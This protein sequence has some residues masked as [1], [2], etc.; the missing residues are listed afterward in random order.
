M[1]RTTRRALRG[2]ASLALTGAVALGSL[3]AST[4]ARAVPADYRVID[5][6]PTGVT[7]DALPTTQID[8]VAWDQKIAGNTV[9][10]GGEFANARPAGAAAGTNLV[11]RANL[12]AYDITTGKLV[13]SFR[14]DTNAAVNVLALSPDGSRLYVGGAF[15]TVGGQN[16]YRLAAINTA[17]GSL[18]PNFAPSI[19]ASVNSIVVTDDA[20]YVGGVFSRANGVA[21]TRLAAFSPADG[22]LLAWAPT[23]NR[24]VKA[25]TVSP[26]GSR[27]IVGGQFSTINGAVSPGTGSIDAV[28]GTLYPFALNKV[29]KNG[30]ANTGIYSLTT[31]G[32]T[33]VGTAFNYGEGLYEGVFMTDPMTGAITW[34]ADCHGDS[35]DATAMRGQVYAVSHHHNCSNVGSFPQFTPNIYK[36]ADAWTYDATGTV[37]TNSQSGYTNYA[38]NPAPS[39]VDW[40]PE[41]AAGT[42]T[43]QAQAAWTS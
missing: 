23:A 12:L 32:T 2:T 31:D 37:K 29:V 17:D 8:G 6:Q 1:S 11:P 34:L 43:G 22:S 20:V 15:T 14:A 21:R 36:R 30:T 39:Q 3:L 9:Y 33:V 40:Y 7:S 13:E 41:L 18:V 5:R 19:D 35:Y 10:V 28:T 26:D 38:G 16:R 4:P 42:Y 27:I 24:N 25:M